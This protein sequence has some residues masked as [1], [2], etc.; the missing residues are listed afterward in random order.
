M[1]SINI[2]LRINPLT[3]KGNQGK[4]G[5]IVDDKVDDDQGKGGEI[6][7]DEGHDDQDKGGEIVDN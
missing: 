3:R 6:A 7:D 2:I 1:L 4:G 5:Y